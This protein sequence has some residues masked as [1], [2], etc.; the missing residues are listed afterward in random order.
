MK[1]F[2]D[3]LWLLVS[4]LV[5]GI[6]F[7]SGCSDD[8]GPF[9][10]PHKYAKIYMPQAVHNPVKEFYLINVDSAQ[11]FIYGA[12]YAGPGRPK[13]NVSIHFSVNPAL[14]DSFNTNHSKSYPILP[15]N[16]YKLSQTESVIPAGELSTS[17]LKIK[18]NK[19]GTIGTAGVAKYLLPLTV[20]VEDSWIPVNKN[21]R[22]TYFLI[23]ASYKLYDRSD[24]KVLGVDSYNHQPNQP[25]KLAIDG[26]IGT[27][28]QT[29]WRSRT[30]PPYYISIDMGGTYKVHGFKI[31][32]RQNQSSGNPVDIV[33]KISNDTTNWGK[34]QH[35]TLPL[36]NNTLKTRVYLSPP[37]KGRYFK[38]IINRTFN[39][40]KFA[41][42]AEIYAF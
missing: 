1:P 9:L 4:I 37:M 36:D 34:G 2:L 28:W 32:G 14:V 13:H 12:V 39:N 17:P 8:N 33:I 23:S 40:A 3:K 29:D 22:T 10:N 15:Q 6:F 25:G 31:V 41:H 18:I 21:L 7:T 38:L 35:F 27:I 11:S 42:I 20:N 16:S 19:K 30:P 24:W 5:V 26:D